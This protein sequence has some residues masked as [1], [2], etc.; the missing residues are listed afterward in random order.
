MKQ[1]LLSILLAVFALQASAQN[2]SGTWNG[3]LDL[4]VA[5]LKIVFHIGTDGSCTLDSPDQ[6]AKGLPAN[7]VYVSADSLNIASPAL[8][9]T[10][11]GK[12]ADGEI[13]GQFSQNGQHLPLTLKPGDVEVRRPQTPKPPYPYETEEVTFTNEKAGATLAGTLTVPNDA[14]TVLLMVTGSGQQDRDETLFEH[15]P[16]AVIADYL[17]RQGIAT[18]RYDDRGFG[19]STGGELKNA[20]TQDIAADAAAGIEWLRNSKRFQ[21]V[22][23]LG[24]SEGGQIAFILGAQGKLDCIVSLAGPAVKG[25]SIILAQTKAI[26]G[27]AAKDLTLEQLYAQPAIQQ[28]I[29]ESAWYRHFLEYDPQADIR[30]V[31]C[32]VLALNGERDKQV[33]ALQ[34]LNSMR[35]NL[36]RNTKT[37][38]KSYPDLNHLF[39]HC[40]SGLPDEYGQI[41][42]TISKEVLKDITDWL[43]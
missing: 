27:P 39:Q 12:L 36:P 31:T 16:F 42:E 41:E 43:K 34:N 6:G 29:K 17:A 5:K 18:L 33:D 22:G 19:Q 1:T 10:Y 14:R 4:G 23:L 8:G 3:V 40:Q 20:T 24:H 28:T 26:A 7:L 32:P 15:K 38:I 11:A 35:R 21:K 13:R 9:M 37:I 2:I 25:D 30:K